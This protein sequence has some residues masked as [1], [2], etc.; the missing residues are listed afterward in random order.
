MI[1]TILHA[2]AFLT[3]FATLTTLVTMSFL[4]MAKAI[5]EDDR[6]D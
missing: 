2:L 6:Y 4:A 5:C 1:N 3:V